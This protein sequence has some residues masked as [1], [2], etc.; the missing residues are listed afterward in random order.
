MAYKELHRISWI[1]RYGFIIHGQK[2]SKI[3]LGTLGLGALYNGGFSMLY[4]KYHIFLQKH[5]ILQE[6]FEAVRW[7]PRSKI[8]YSGAGD[9]EKWHLHFVHTVALYM[10]GAILPRLWKCCKATVAK[11]SVTM[12]PTISIR[13]WTAPK[14]ICYTSCLAR[15]PQLLFHNLSFHL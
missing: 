9:T 12:A 15:A 13:P 1:L 14:R 3:H 2:T 11:N 7:L 8:R 5:T 4:I 10:R 6:G